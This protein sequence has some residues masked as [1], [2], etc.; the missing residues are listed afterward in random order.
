MKQLKVFISS[1]QKEF[2]NE[3]KLL[4][5]HFHTDAL[6]SCFFEPV[7]F[8]KLS[9]SSQAPNKVYLDEVKQSQVYLALLGQEYGYEDEKGVSPTEMEYLQARALHLDSLAFIKG[10]SSISRHEKKKHYQ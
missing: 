7:M 4:F 1:V 8:E 2:A 6:L 3:R 5:L 9:A 10:K